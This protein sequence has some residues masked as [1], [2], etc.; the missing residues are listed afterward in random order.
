V[1]SFGGVFPVFSLDAS[2]WGLCFHPTTPSL[3]PNASRRGVLLDFLPPL[4]S[5]QAR[6]GGVSSV[7][8]APTPPSPQMRAGGF[9]S[10]RRPLSSASPPLPLLRATSPLSPSSCPLSVVTASPSRR[11]C[12]LSLLSLVL[13]LLSLVLPLPLIAPPPLFFFHASSPPCPS[14]SICR[15]ATP[16]LPS[17]PHTAAAPLHT[18][19]PPPSLPLHA[20]LPPLSTQRRRPHLCLSL[21]RHR[22]T[23][24][25]SMLRRRRRLSTQR[26]KCHATPPPCRV[27]ATAASAPSL[28]PSAGHLP[29]PCPNTRGGVC[30]LGRSPFPLLPWST[31]VNM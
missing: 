15:V 31:I 13:S 29:L 4:Y 21:P 27:A 22:V 5:L 10:R 6:A 25:L 20:A 7:S 9:L 11:W 23:P 26:H 28:V 14:L 17:P 18:A 1:E 2:R 16:A 30:S 3:A 12:S 8:R 24:S 19:S